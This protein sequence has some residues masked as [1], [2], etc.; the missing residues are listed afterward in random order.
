MTNGYGTY[1]YCLFS[2][3]AELVEKKDI[4]KILSNI[5]FVLAG[6][7]WLMGSWVF[8]GLHNYANRLPSESSWYLEFVI[9]SS[10]SFLYFRWETLSLAIGCFVLGI[11]CLWWHSRKQR[12]KG[13][14]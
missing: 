10:K 14:L 1:N 3:L 13:L 5:C 8:F 6:I 7:F 11:F 2:A 9:M 12:K 4:M